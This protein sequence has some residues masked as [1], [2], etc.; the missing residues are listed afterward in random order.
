M[1]ARGGLLKP[2]RGGAYLVNEPMLR[3]LEMGAR[4]YHPSNLGA[5]IAHGIAVEV[6]V[7][8]FIIDPVCV[9]ELEPEARLSGL[10]ELPRVS[11]SHAL[12]SKAVAKSVARKLGKRYQDVNLVVAHMGSGVSVSS[13]RKG[14]M[15]DVNDARSEGPFAADR[16]GGLPAW[17]LAKLCYS[18]KYTEEQ[19][20]SR[21]L[22]SGGLFAYLGTRDLRQAELQ[23]TEGA[24]DAA[25]TLRAMAYQV[26]KEIGAMSAVLDG[27]VD[28]IILTG[29]MAHS[30]KLVDAITGRVA[31]IAPVV[32]VPGE[33][34][35]EALAA[36][37]LRVLAQEE[38]ALAYE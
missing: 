32:V 35:L 18:G 10:P 30:Q 19:M 36:G 31:F 5:S 4:G 13:H 34:E 9:D 17:A 21:I 7:P 28:R 14:Q 26:A 23:S 11:L 6:G 2:L 29:G 1:V 22:G 25:L 20:L 38:E 15:V 24:V 37:A 3:D 12:N 16:S 33:E 27:A 8:A